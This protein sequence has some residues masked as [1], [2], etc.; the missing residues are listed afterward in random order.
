MKIFGIILAFLIFGISLAESEEER[1][2]SMFKVGDDWLALPEVF[3]NLDFG[4]DNTPA[5]EEDIEGQMRHRSTSSSS[6][7]WI[8]TAPTR[9]SPETPSSFTC[10]L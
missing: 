2:P 5:G 3:S 10:E 7:R 1:Q 4:A 9:L 8:S 6:T